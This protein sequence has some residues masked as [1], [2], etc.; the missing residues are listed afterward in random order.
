MMLFKISRVLQCALNLRCSLRSLM[1][2]L[3]FPLSMVLS[4]VA[5]PC[6]LW[7]SLQMIVSP[8]AKEISTGRVSSQLFCQFVGNF[9][10]SSMSWD[11][12]Q[13]YHIIPIIPKVVYITLPHFDFLSGNVFFWRN[14]K[15]SFMALTVTDIL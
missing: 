11:P 8:V 1:V 9:L 14:S 5:P 15:I 13:N 12:D 7:N 6:L 2:M 10:D 3:S 4:C